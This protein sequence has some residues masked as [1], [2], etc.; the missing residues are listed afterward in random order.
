MIDGFIPADMDF[1]MPLVNLIVLL[2]VL[3]V[4][5]RKMVVAFLQKRTSR[6]QDQFD[7]AE[8]EKKA[9]ENLKA[10]YTR[11]LQDAEQE[12]AA[13]M[14]AAHKQAED[15]GREQLAEAKEEAKAVAA[16]ALKEVELERERVSDEVQR[17][18]I[19]A[20]AAI[21]GKFLAGVIDAKTHERLFD[22]TMKELEEAAWHS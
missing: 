20:S 22:E 17:T 16:R 11:H 13:L 12:S 2:I 10:K 6:I 14:A 8:S 4:A 19:T 21:T 18:I 1:I 7:L 3:S 9:A 5:L 15:S